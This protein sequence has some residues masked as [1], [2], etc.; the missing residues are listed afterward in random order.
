MKNAIS[1]AI[2]CYGIL[3]NA[4]VNADNIASFNFTPSS[5]WDVPFPNDIFTMPNLEMITQRRVNLAP[6][7]DPAQD[8][9]RKDTESVNALDGFSIFPR[10]TIPLS[11]VAPDVDSFTSANVFLVGLAP[12][13]E[14]GRVIPVDQ[15]IIDIAMAD[16][17]RLIFVP[18]GYLKAQARYAIVV[19]T[20][21]TG[22]G[23]PYQ[24]NAAFKSF[25]DRYQRRVAP[26]GIYEA[27]L[28]DAVDVLVSGGLATPA[29]LATLS[30][31]TTRTV[32]DVPTKLMRRLTDGQFQVSPPRLSFDG[33]SRLEIWRADGIE[34]IDSYIHRA[35]LPANGTSLA[36]FPPNT[37][38]I[39]DSDL[40]VSTDLNDDVYI[41]NI[42]NSASVLVP[43][44]TIDAATGAITNVNISS[45]S[46]QP[47]DELAVF[48]RKRRLS[49]ST[50]PYFWGSLGYIAFGVV[51]V[52]RYT[53]SNGVIPAIPTGPNAIPPQT[54]TDSIV[55]ALFVPL[56][57]TP[58][59]TPSSPTTVTKLAMTAEATAS[60]TEWPVVHLLHGGAE[61]KS[62][63]LSSDVLNMAPILASRGIATVAFTA[64]EF[65]GG[66]RSKLIIT[67]SYGSRAIPGTGRA[68]DVDGNGL[69]EKTEYY[70]Y[71]QRISDLATVLRSVQMGV[72]LNGDGVSDF[73]T[74]AAKTYIA[75]ISYGGATA[76]ISA[77][78]EPGASAF[79]ANVPTGEGSRS[80]TAGFHPVVGYRGRS[81]AQEKMAA[82]TPSLINGPSPTWG[83]TFNEDIPLKRLPVQV[84][85]VAGAEAIQRAFDFNMWR[86]LVHMPLAY[87]EHV[88]TGALRGT[89]ATLL[90]QVARG[91]GS[92]VNPIQSLMI[93][94]GGL[95]NKTAVIRLDNEPRFDQQWAPSILPELARHVLIALPYAPGN[96]DIELAG[97]ISHYTR[98]QIAEYLR[99]QGSTVTDA[100]GSGGVFAG[101]VF[102]FPVSS[103]V[104]D[105][106]LLNP[107]IPK[108]L[109]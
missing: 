80:R 2:L 69:Y 26:A 50:R 61:S 82:R 98:V 37:L 17:P 48:V 59:T 15:R 86:D 84:G 99:T 19:T 70:I 67:T 41:Q 66:P 7:A 29:N 4:T 1:A 38:R 42:R 8:S 105:E 55:I 81:F 90:V 95:E 94:A 32:H 3:L 65:E 12:S 101:D 46:P 62:S 83:G 5:H 11:G 54:G 79:V 89:P 52:P 18:D 22:G 92:A 43:P 56:T 40:T 64:A 31:F 106:M 102:Q 57:P 20:G 85:M 13:Q 63:F 75:G 6:P 27:T 88:G 91:D 104:L 10:I 109:P 33:R 35:S 72:D 103:S 108:S 93:R 97:R 76:F 36:S 58:A 74:T 47:N 78:L 71:P 51:D 28:T 60:G 49:T 34:S 87:A 96:P 14:R 25:I 44:N 107:G 39:Q 77:A 9:E 21:L 53:G 23:Q 45:L 68:I 30:V 73:A 100:D 24:G 16:A